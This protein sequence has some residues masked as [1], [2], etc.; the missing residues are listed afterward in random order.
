[1]QQFDIARQH[2]DAVAVVTGEVGGHQMVGDVG[3]LLRSAAHGTDDESDQL[4]KVGG[5]DGRHG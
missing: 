4:V 3:R 2:A 1:M 5:G